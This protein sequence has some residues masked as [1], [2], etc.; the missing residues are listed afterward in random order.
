[1][2]NFTHGFSNGRAAYVVNGGHVVQTEP[3]SD[4]I[5]EL[6]AIAVVF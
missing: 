6:Q 5:V 1:M 4:Q 2:L 3:A